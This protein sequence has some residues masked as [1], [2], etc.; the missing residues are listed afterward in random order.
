MKVELRPYQKA[1][2]SSILEN[3]N[4]LVVLPT[5]LGKSLIAFC[6]MALKGGGLMLAPT[7]P[8]AEQ[9]HRNFTALGFPAGLA[10]GDVRK[11]RYAPFTFATPQTVLRDMEKGLLD[12]NT[13]PVVVFDEAHRA[14]GEYAYVKIAQ[15]YQGLIVGLTASPGG[16]VER[17]EEVLR[18]LKISNVEV[19]TEEDEDVKPYVKE[20]RIRWVYVSMTPTMRRIKSL[21]DELVK[22]YRDKFREL[23]FP[24]IKGKKDLAALAKKLDA[25][26]GPSRYTLF[27]WYGMLLNLIHMLELLQ[28]QG[29]HALK[30]Y[31]EK[32]DRRKKTVQLLFKEP[33][34]L[35]VLSL[36]KEAEEHPKVG[37]LVELLRSLKGKRGMVFVQYIDQIEHLCGILE[38]EGFRVKPFVGKRIMGRRE[39]RKVLEDFRKGAY[40][41]LLSSSVGEE[42][43]DVPEMDFVV[44]YEPI[45]SEIRLIQRRGRAGRAKVGE[46]YILV[47]RGTLDEA[48][49]WA[50]RK[51]ERKML[52]FLRRLSK[53][54]KARREKGPISLSKEEGQE[55]GPA[56]G[57]GRAEGTAQ[58]P[59]RGRG[60]NILDWL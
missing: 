6:I 19:R 38:K 55:K 21:L 51:R 43:I 39:Q 20:K 44:F 9:H 28:T 49:L 1:I 29:P 42:G 52:S 41:V 54:R 7:K 30:R 23:G 18:N 45:P 36:L 16:N 10:T 24:S 59:K 32:L 40:D 15:P 14:V 53:E 22:K 4:T 56:Q 26:K 47:T 13:F 5:G 35:E 34:F 58:P 50:S 3:G 33:A 12:I 31:V 46:I 25:L 57:G 60:P 11:R 17:I 27:T 8:L 37:K 2:V 48:F